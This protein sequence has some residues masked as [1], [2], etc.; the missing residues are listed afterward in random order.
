MRK[1]API[2]LAM[3]LATVTARAASHRLSVG[4]AQ[5]EPGK[6]AQAA[7]W[8]NRATDVA[9]IEFQLNY[10]PYQLSLA[11]VTNPVGSLG[12]AFGLDFENNDGVAIVRLYREDGLVSGTG[13]LA[14]VTFSVNE[15]ATPGMGSDLTVASC[16]LGNEFG[17]DIRW[18]NSIFQQ[19]GRFWVTYSSTNDADGDGLSDYQEQMINGSG[20]YDPGVTDTDM[21]N[22]DTDGD[23]MNDGEEWIAGTGGL[24]ADS[25]FEIINPWVLTANDIVIRWPSATGRLYRIDRATN[26]TSEIMFTPLVDSVTPSPPMNTYT[27]T[28]ADAEATLFYRIRV[29]R[30]E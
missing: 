14:L 17:G 12:A 10:D 8:L 7:V 18:A 19:N 6:T 23:G 20:D 16:G 25:I 4:E 26:L 28:T 2:L 22:P 5:G 27:D 24:D 1:T 21:N 30:N 29:R 9:S 11:G 3:A 13:L 15:G